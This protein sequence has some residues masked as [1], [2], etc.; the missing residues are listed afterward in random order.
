[1]RKIRMLKDNERLGFRKGEIYEVEPY[2]LDPQTKLSAVRK[3]PASG[4]F[5]VY[6]EGKGEEWEWL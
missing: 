5:N 4:G 3:I 6:R 2:W 1:M